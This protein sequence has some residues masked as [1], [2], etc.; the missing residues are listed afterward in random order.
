MNLIQKSKNEVKANV[1]RTCS[2][3]VLAW[4]EERVSDWTR[5]ERISGIVLKYVQLMKLKLSS[6]SDVLTAKRSGVVDF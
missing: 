4:L 3:S 6:P 2:D 1:T 5:M